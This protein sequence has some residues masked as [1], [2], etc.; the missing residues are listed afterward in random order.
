MKHLFQKIII[1]SSVNREI[2]RLG[3]Y[4][5]D[6]S[7]F[8]NS[9]WIHIQDPLDLKMEKGLRDS[10]DAGG[11]AAITL[12]KELNADYLAIDERA[13]RRVA[14]SLGIKIIGLVGILIRGKEKN[15]IAAVKPVLDE[16]MSKANFYIGHKFYQQILQ[17]LGE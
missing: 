15:Q 13:G 8:R 7:K 1:P 4:G 10:L 6:L 3:E 9:D 11:S 2:L 12:A 17:E 5:F 16:L 14:K